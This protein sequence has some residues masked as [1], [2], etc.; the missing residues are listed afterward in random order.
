MRHED[1]I[2]MAAS[3]G[4]SR[5]NPNGENEILRLAT[6]L[7]FDVVNG[8]DRIV[9]VYKKISNVTLTNYVNRDIC[10][11][12]Y[13]MN[14]PLWERLNDTKCG[15]FWTNGREIISSYYVQKKTLPKWLPSYDDTKSEVENMQSIGFARF[16][17][18][19][20]MKFRLK[21]V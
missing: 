2:V 16:F 8:L 3:I 20:N 6:K 7:G 1:E 21:K 15:Y 4:K 19:G 9:R 18:S 10:D 13:Y 11:T 12:N 5:F 17:D 14:N